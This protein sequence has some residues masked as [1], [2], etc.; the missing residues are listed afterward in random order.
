MP[1]GFVKLVRKRGSL[2]VLRPGP[3]PRG[4]RSPAPHDTA[5]CKRGHRIGNAFARLKD[6]RGIATRCDRCGELFPTAI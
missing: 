2:P 3:A 5:L 1:N 4:N 6:W